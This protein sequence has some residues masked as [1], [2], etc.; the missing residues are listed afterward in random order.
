M[1]NGGEMSEGVIA[2]Y[3]KENYHELV[4]EKTILNAV[5]TTLVYG[6]VDDSPSMTVMITDDEHLQEMNQRYRGIDKPTDVLAFETDFTDPDLD[7][8]YLGDV[9]ISYQQAR[10]Q[11]EMR[12]HQVEEELQLLVVHGVLHLLG[13]DHDSPS[14]KEEM[15]SL[16]SQ[17][18][19]DLGLSIEVEDV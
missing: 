9:V 7:S 18:L 5:E 17:A 13:F 3:V 4:T 16:Q 19:N 15:W 6:R 8:R 11:A 14:G 10:I 12:G 1:K 2:F